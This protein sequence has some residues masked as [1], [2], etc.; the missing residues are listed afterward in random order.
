MTASDGGT[1]PAQALVSIRP[2]EALDVNGGRCISS[3]CAPRG[4]V[5][6]LQGAGATVAAGHAIAVDNHVS[7]KP[8]GSNPPHLVQAGKPGCRARDALEIWHGDR[9]PL[10]RHEP[11]QLLCLCGVHI[12]TVQQIPDWGQSETDREIVLVVTEGIRPLFLQVLT[13]VAIQF[14]KNARVTTQC[15]EPRLKGLFPLLLGGNPA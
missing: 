12:L 9:A 4:N 13:I 3:L 2:V 1:I 11:L 15:F 5:V 6:E 14:E 8:P 7:T 10:V